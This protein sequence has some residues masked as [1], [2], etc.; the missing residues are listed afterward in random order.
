MPTIPDEIFPTCRLARADWQYRDRDSVQATRSNGDLTALAPMFRIT[1]GATIEPASGTVRDFFA[2]TAHI[3][4]D[5]GGRRMGRTYEVRITAEAP[6][7]RGEKVVVNYDFEKLLP[8]TCE[9]EVL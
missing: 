2:W 6:A 5:I 1:E 8:R 7:A 4:G 3:Q 9:R